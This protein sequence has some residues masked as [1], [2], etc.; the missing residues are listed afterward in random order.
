MSGKNIPVML[1]TG[2]EDPSIPPPVQKKLS[3]LIPQIE[4]REIIGVG[5]FPHFEKPVEVGLLCLSFWLRE[6][7]IRNSST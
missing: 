3:Q 2:S 4:M 7:P 5:H 6:E 1:I